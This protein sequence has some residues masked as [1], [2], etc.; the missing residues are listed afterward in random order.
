MSKKVQVVDSTEAPRDKVHA[1]V[2][3]AQA[4]A[5]ARRYSQ[6]DLDA[7]T[8]LALKEGIFT[9]TKAFARAVGVSVG[10][11]DSSLARVKRQDR[12]KEKGS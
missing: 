5:A 12:Q 10:R 3:Q 2:L 4:Q 7:L 8:R 9:T 6:D 11:A 1:A